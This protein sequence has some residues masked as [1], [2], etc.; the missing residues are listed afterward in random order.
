MPQ[1][2]TILKIL[3]NV[4]KIE[5][6]DYFL[7][8]HT[9]TVLCKYHSVFLSQ[10]GQVYTC[11]HGQGGRLG[12]DDE[13]TTLEPRLL[14]T[15]K[16]FTCVEIAAATGSFFFF[17]LMFLCGDFMQT[18]VTMFFIVNVLEV[19]PP[20]WQVLILV[21]LITDIAASGNIIL[22]HFLKDAFPVLSIFSSCIEWILFWLG[23]TLTVPYNIQGLHCWPYCILA[24]W[25]SYHL[26]V[27]YALFC[28][29]GSADLAR[30][31]DVIDFCFRGPSWQRNIVVSFR[32]AGKS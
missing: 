26:L 14:D 12:H 6:K 25:E 8:P 24:W 32:V 10:S 18:V 23:M 21:K 17:L 30:L 28:L 5:W 27:I 2:C 4:Y 13:H 3:A 29:S 1:T 16:D 20:Y 31:I 11:G 22:T 19:L 9:Q 15:V 7:I